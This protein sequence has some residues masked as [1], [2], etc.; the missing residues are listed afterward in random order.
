M[1][2]RQYDPTTARFL[3][4][5]PILNLADPQQ[6]NGYSYANNTPITLSD[7]TGLE[8]QGGPCRNGTNSAGYSCTQD[9]DFVN[10][11][12]GANQ[13]RYRV[14]TGQNEDGSKQPVVAGV[15]I[16][17]YKELKGRVVPGRA[18]SYA[19]ATSSYSEALQLWT[20]S[21]CQ[22]PRDGAADFCAA[23]RDAGLL[24]IDRHKALDV[25]VSGLIV[26]GATL[27]VA[28]AAACAIAEPCGAIVGGAVA[29]STPEGALFAPGAITAGA[30]GFA[31]LATAARPASAI[32]NGV[33]GSGRAALDYATSAAK[34]DHIFAAKHN[35]DPLV[36]RFGSRE[37]VVQKFLDGLNGMTPQAGVFEQKIVI[38]GQ[39]VIVRGAVVNGVTKI[40]T[41]FTP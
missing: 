8:P 19:A 22:N 36:Q 24:G 18:S 28:G 12:S 35:F 20:E 32:G 37:A 38:G 41:A 40:G 9:T 39:S 17:T 30:S 2:A 29:A 5:D 1:G 13:D 23:A 7:P 11:D 14:A 21:M 6:W 34:L 4:T 31:R 33:T 27:A 25:M 15:R 16:P 26:L 10:L 3:S